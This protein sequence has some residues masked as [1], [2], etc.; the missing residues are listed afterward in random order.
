LL[1][2]LLLDELPTTLAIIG[3]L[4]TLLGVIFSNLAV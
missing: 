3:G 2:Y 1:S 4:I